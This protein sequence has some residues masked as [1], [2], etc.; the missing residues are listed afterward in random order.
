MAVNKRKSEK[1]IKPKEKKNFS[2]EVS[3]QENTYLAGEPSERH[4][5]RLLGRGLRSEYGLSTLYEKIGGD[6]ATTFVDFSSVVCTI[7]GKK[8]QIHVGNKKEAS[9]KDYTGSNMVLIEQECYS[10]Y[11][12]EVLAYSA[13]DIRLEALLDEHWI[14]ADGREIEIFTLSVVLPLR[15]SLK[16]TT[17]TSGDHF[18]GT[19]ITFDGES[20]QLE[21]REH[22]I[23][24]SFYV[25]AE[26][27]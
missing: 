26:K 5:T 6:V 19:L 10:V 18:R 24:E 4:L 1:N 12:T 22:D 2:I 21:E 23:S 8:A 9:L 14:F 25:Y 7:N 27:N 16:W 20:H 15:V 11:T 13:D 3:G 17:G